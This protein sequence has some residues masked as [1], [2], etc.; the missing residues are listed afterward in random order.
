MSKDD[1][2][3]ISLEELSAGIE[4]VNHLEYVALKGATAADAEALFAAIDSDGQGA[5]LLGEVRAEC[6]AAH[7]EPGLG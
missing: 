5:V 6:V 3:K 1:D 2:R 4:S 7:S